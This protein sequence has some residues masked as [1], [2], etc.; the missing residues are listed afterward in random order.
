M[1]AVPDEWDETFEDIWGD[2]EEVCAMAMDENR[3]LNERDF[4]YVDDAT[5]RMVAFLR[6]TLDQKTS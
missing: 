6:Q 3:N 2:L 1:E 5:T 4:G